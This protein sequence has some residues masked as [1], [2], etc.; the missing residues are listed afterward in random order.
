MKLIFNIHET[1]IMRNLFTFL[2]TA[3]VSTGLF[4]Q[5]CDLFFS[6]YIE[7]SSNN[8]ALEIY[9]PTSASADLSNYIVYRA[10][11][12]ATLPSDSLLLTGI[13][14]A[15]EVFVIGN[16]SADIDIIAESDTLHTITFY[17]GDDAIFLVN[18]IT[19]DTL[20]I[21]GEIG[22]DP[23]SSW[24]IDTLGGTQNYTL[25]R[26]A[27]I[28]AGNTDWMTASMEWD[29]YPQDDFSF[30]G[31]H[32]GANCGACIPTFSMDV[33]TSC[34]D[35]MWA[36]DSMMYTMSGTYYDTLVNAAGCDSI[37][38][39][40]LT[41]VTIDTTFSMTLGEPTTFM[42]NEMDSSATFQWM[43]CDSNGTTTPIIGETTN[44][45]TPT[46]SGNYALEITL[47]GCVQTTNCMFVDVI[48]S[49]NENAAIQ[50][51]NVYPNPTMG[52]TT[53]ELGKAY[54]GVEVVTRN[55]VGQIVDA[56]TMGYTDRFELNIE[57]QGIFVVTVTTAS[58]ETTTF[59]LV[60]Q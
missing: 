3:L 29:V 2:L 8:K 7:G 23:G 48:S 37:I 31:S 24:A 26:N 57:G 5:N 11:N 14:D 50:N 51:I 1:T 28:S 53:V 33:E 38:T 30:L 46:T 6:E 19:G 9:N 32:T 16:S 4:A 17:N 12:G 20:D 56:R 45:Y 34:G 47:N 59:R 35:F 27:A 25:V 41:V 39:L 44:T 42:S 58:G 54:E 60:K 43:T 21:I 52:A 10:N 40:Q 13:L 49:I 18:T 22:I 55:M 36:V 15:G